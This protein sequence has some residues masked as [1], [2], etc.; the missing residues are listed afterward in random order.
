[1]IKS[2]IMECRLMTLTSGEKQRRH[3]KAVARSAEIR[4]IK[5]L[6]AAKREARFRVMNKV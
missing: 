3:E 5:A 2:S 1:M 4:R 6:R